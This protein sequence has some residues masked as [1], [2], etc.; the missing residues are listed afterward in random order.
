MNQLQRFG[1]HSAVYGLYLFVACLITYP[2]VTQFTTHFAGNL[3]GPG[4]TEEYARHI[5]W[6]AHAIQR[7]EPLFYQPLFAY[8][9]GLPSAHLWANLL[10]SFPAA[11]YG[12]FLP[13]PAAF[14][15]MILTRLALN[16][17]TMWVLIRELTRQGEQRT[18]IPAFLA[19]I[20][21]LALPIVQGHL[22][23]SHSGLITLYPY[24]LL[25]LFTLRLIQRPSKRGMRITALCF[26]G[27]IL[28]SYALAIYA[29]APIGILLLW[30]SWRK[31]AFRRVFSAYL[32]GGLLALIFL[33]PAALEILQ[34]P[35]LQLGGAVEFSADL[36]AVVAPSPWNPLG[37]QLDYP[38]YFLTGNI[39]EGTAYLGVIGLG[40]ALIAVC[41]ERRARPFALLGIVVWVFSLGPFLKVGGELI[42]FNLGDG[43]LSPVSLPW[44]GFQN[45]PFLNIARTPAR[46]N[47]AL[48]LVV[49]VM[50]GYGAAVVWHWFQNKMI[51]TRAVGFGLFVFVG[52]FAL[53]EYQV[54]SPFPTYD[55]TLPQ[56][57]YDLA[58]RENIRAVMD[59]PLNTPTN[60][61]ALYTQTAHQHPL[62]AG[63]ITRGTPVNPAQVEILSTILDPALLDLAGVDV[64]ILHRAWA[65]IPP[66]DEAYTRS[67]LGDPFYEDADYA[68][69]NVPEPDQAPALTILPIPEQI[70]LGDA[71]S[72]WNIRLFVPSAG[73]L[74]LQG[75]ALIDA[76]ALEIQLLGDSLHQQ[77]GQW[78]RG[79][80]HLEQPIYFPAMGY[81]MLQLA[82]MPACAIRPPSPLA[83]REV[84]LNALQL[85][86]FVPVDAV[87]IYRTPHLLR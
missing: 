41:F 3:P 70:V 77:V 32:I 79:T 44:A 47:F 48:A 78:M 71:V 49:V 60:K 22:G 2:L 72:V 59:L 61:A 34:T 50:A 37:I 38:R 25:I 45:L 13:L 12:L 39:V 35:Q 46:F 81:Y 53:W 21:F 83:C 85:S 11:L 40:L 36:L 20:L 10:Q 4:D 68:L 17:W 63:S 28:G 23:A 54:F 65:G 62:M 51:L 15:V 16:G 33:I 73:W 74:T 64:I 1:L 56:A 84:T 9:D 24:P 19:G 76:P 57:L 31:R 6:F 69:F 5:W 29:L 43:Y 58:E 75:D 8:P 27:C 80:T 42:Q 86:E 52:A 14:N 30:M 7:G 18:S 55:A 87:Q 67:V 66:F 82:G 26:V